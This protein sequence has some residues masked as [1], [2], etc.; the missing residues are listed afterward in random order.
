MNACVPCVPSIEERYRA[1]RE[2][3]TLGNIWRWSW[4]GGPMLLDEDDAGCFLFRH[5]RGFKRRRMAAALKGRRRTKYQ[6]A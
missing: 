5:A 2:Q 4:P 6:A 1:F 3:I